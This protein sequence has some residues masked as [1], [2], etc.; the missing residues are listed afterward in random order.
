MPVVGTSAGAER[1]VV[2]LTMLKRSGSA[3]TGSRLAAHA[4]ERGSRC[5]PT[6][7]HKPVGGSSAIRMVICT[8]LPNPSTEDLHSTAEPDRSRSARNAG[9]GRVAGGGRSPLPMRLVVVESGGE[10]Q[11][12][13]CD[14]PVDMAR[15]RPPAP[16]R[17]RRAGRPAGSRRR[18]DEQVREAH[19]LVE[20]DRRHGG[21]SGAGS[22]T[23]GV[24]PARGVGEAVIGGGTP[25]AR[26]SA[27]G[28]GRGAVAPRRPPRP[29]GRV[30]CSPAR[31]VD[32]DV[33]APPAAA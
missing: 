23:R 4:L 21:S 25:A 26:R 3:A 17:A 2:R 29:L 22:S 32:V 16:A 9:A 15:R 6:S 10:Q 11:D 14:L 12:R 30:R 8:G 19:H 5:S 18:S 1:N 7:L 24:R 33:S 28:R 20:L 13:A 27:T 31:P